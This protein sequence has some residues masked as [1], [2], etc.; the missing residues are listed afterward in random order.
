MEKNG[1]MGTVEGLEE[2]MAEMYGPGG[3]SKARKNSVE[4]VVVVESEREQ[5]MQ[6]FAQEASEE[7]V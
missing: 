1:R 2:M 3:V 5:V 7:E 6:E 4:T